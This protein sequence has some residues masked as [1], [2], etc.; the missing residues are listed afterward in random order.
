MDIILLRVAMGF[1]LVITL[2]INSIDINKIVWNDNC[3]KVNAKNY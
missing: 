2:I 3:L 1:V